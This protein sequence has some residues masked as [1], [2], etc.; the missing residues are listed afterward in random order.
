MKWTLGADTALQELKAHLSSMRT[1]VAPKPRE[2]LL[3]YLAATN[4]V[5]SAALVAQQEAEDVES[6]QI[7]AGSEKNQD[8]NEHDNESN[9]K[10]VARKKWCSA[11]YTWSAPCCKGLDQGI[12]VCKS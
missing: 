6:G 2:P 5:F 4:K 3:L 10:D 7:T 12:L 9:P 11:Q 1:L 8:N